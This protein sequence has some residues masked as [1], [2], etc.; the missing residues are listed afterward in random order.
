M[1][2]EILAGPERRRRWSD[3]EKA[4]IVAEAAAPGTR[5][6]DIARRHGVSRGLI[7][8]WRREASQGLSSDGLAAALPELIPVVVSDA[9]REA[10]SP[11]AAIE[12]RR[13]CSTRVV[14]PDSEIEIMLPSGV[15]VMVRGRV[16]ERTLRALLGAL[17][18]A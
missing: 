1:K 10:A 3:G 18:S 4:R 12:K 6:A 15:R 11:E 5:V 2:A 16:E 13:T 7:Y 17:R 8:T 9:R 14:E